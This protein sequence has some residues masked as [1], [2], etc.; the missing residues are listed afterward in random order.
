M[1]FVGDS[2]KQFLSDI[3]KKMSNKYNVS[4]LSASNRIINTRFDAFL[5]RNYL[6]AK[7]KSIDYWT[8]V[9]YAKSNSDET[10]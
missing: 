4:A 5:R 1:T 10:F 3:C 7:S 6:L 2:I 9:I 8:D